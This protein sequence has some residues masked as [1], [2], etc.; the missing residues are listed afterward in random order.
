MNCSTRGDLLAIGATDRDLSRRCAAGELVRIRRGVYGAP[1]DVAPT[2]RHRRLIEATLP[3]LH[4]DA[5]LSAWSAAVLHGLPVRLD[6]LT[7]VS[8]TRASPAHGRR[9]RVVTQATSPLPPDEVVEM[10]GRAVTS[11]AR[12]V[13]DLGRCVPFEWGVIACDAALRRGGDP[14]ALEQA[15]ERGRRRRGNAL[16]RRVLAASDARSESPLESLSRVQLARHHVPVPELQY[17][18]RLGGRLVARSDF[19]WPERRTVGEADGRV[20]YGALVRD[21]ESVEDVVMREKAR[22]EEIRQAGFWPVRWG[23]AEA[24]DGARL[25]RLVLR[26]FEVAPRA[27]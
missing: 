25:A 17:E 13:A 10:D 4:P 24:W 14:A 12:T 18:V 22:Q 2:E 19:G 7:T 20:K 11:L 15:V 16:A 21:G 23:W 3:G 27:S 6:D 26:A 5:V 9:G 1:A 8:V